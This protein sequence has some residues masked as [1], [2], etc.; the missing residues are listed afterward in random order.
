MQTECSQALRK[1]RSSSMAMA[2]WALTFCGTRY[3]D[4]FLPE[5]GHV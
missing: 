1:E 4:Q 5:N 3:V 2:M